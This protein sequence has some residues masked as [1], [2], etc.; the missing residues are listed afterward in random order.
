MVRG[1]ELR[2]RQAGAGPDDDD[3]RL[4]VARI[5]ADLLEAARRGER[6]DRVDDRP[7]ARERHARGDAHH[8]RLRDAAV[9]EAL[10]GVILELVE[11][12]VPD[13]AR[14]Q[15]D[16]RVGRAEPGDFVRECVSHAASFSVTPSS[17]HAAVTSAAV[18]IR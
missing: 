5:D 17:F 7:Q 2:V 6:R 15:D 13:I 8:V 10:L 9:V 3:R 12:L 11:K 14:Q 16:A 1:S 4:V 18:G